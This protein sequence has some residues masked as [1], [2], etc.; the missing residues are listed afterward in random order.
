[1]ADKVKESGT[2]DGP[3]QLKTPS[4]QSEIEAHRDEGADPPAL[5]V[6]AGGT[7]ARYLLRSLT[8]LHVML[9]AHGGWMPLGSVMEVLGLAEV[10]HNPG[11]NRMRAV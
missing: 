6:A 10:E 5:V 1:M 3:W 9:K 8:D 2:R 4:G 11:N 7:E